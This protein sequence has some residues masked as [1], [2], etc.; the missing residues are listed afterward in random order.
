M[1]DKIFIVTAINDDRQ[2][3]I[4]GVY[5]SYYMAVERMEFSA[6]LGRWTDIRS[7][8]VEVSTFGSDLG[9]IL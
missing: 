3:V 4:L 1:N 7:H 8:E 2:H 9:I 6:K 5:P